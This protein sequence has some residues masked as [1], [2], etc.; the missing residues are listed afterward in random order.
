MFQQVSKFW[1][2]FVERDVCK[3]MV[4]DWICFAKVNYDIFGGQ[5]WYLSPLFRDSMNIEFAADIVW[6]DGS[7]ASLSWEPVVPTENSF[8]RR[9]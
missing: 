7:S 6:A 2:H 9:K 3:T 8:H 4:Y 5:T 1:L